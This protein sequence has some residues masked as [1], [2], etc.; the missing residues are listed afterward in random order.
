M[1]TDQKAMLAAV[2]QD[3]GNELGIQPA[4]VKAQ[5]TRGVAYYKRRLLQ[6]LEG[7]FVL[8]VPEEWDEDYLLDN[9]LI[10][11][12]VV[13]TDTDAGILPLRAGISGFNVFGK[14]VDVQIANPVLGNLERKVGVDSVVIYLNGGGAYGAWYRG[15][16]EILR[17]YAQ[18]LASCDQSIDVG[19]MNTRVSAIFNCA[20]SKQAETAKA[21]YDKISMGEPA[22]FMRKEGFANSDDGSMIPEFLPVKNAYVV[23]LIQEEKRLIMEEFLTEIG[24]NNLNIRKRERST[25]DEIN[26]NNEELICSVARWQE[27][28]DKSCRQIKNMFGI[29]CSIK[30]RTMI[31]EDD[32]NADTGEYM[33]SS[34]DGIE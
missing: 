11:G 3:A 5:R 30:I 22:V 15:V 9:L 2:L 34:E 32:K 19:L 24:I 18:K 6:V 29:D 8:N 7:Q 14:P 16:D 25:T 4:S 23:D 20:T 21:M 26:A 10:E 27:N 13:V 33:G 12:K 28:L 31:K 1:A 17:R